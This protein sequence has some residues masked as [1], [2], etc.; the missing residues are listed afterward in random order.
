M[1][2]FQTMVDFFTEDNWPFV[3][4]ED[5]EM[6]RIPFNGE[7]GHWMCT[8]VSKEDVHQFAFYSTLLFNAPEEKR[9]A[10]AEFITRANYGLI[11]GNWELDFDDGEIRYKTS[12]DIEGDEISTA[13]IKQVVHANVVITDK[14]FPGI[15]EIINN[16]M[17]PQE[18]I[19]LVE[20]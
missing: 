15:V 10:V 7:N 16:D 14:Y 20:S 9:M 5:V 3:A 6:L 8:A 19:T 12:L 2:I 4:V 13:L 18:A 11:I 1:S 17:L